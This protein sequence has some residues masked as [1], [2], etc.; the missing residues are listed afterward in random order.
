MQ[1]SLVASGNNVTAGKRLAHC[2]RHS[3]RLWLLFRRLETARQPRRRRKSH[4]PFIPTSYLRDIVEN[5][6]KLGESVS[7][8][9]RAGG[10]RAVASTDKTQW[11]RRRGAPPANYGT[12][13]TVGSFSWPPV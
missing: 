2:D 5:K 13:V 10:K 12:T 7:A 8:F 11:H 3:S 4:C 1:D 6:A 9:S